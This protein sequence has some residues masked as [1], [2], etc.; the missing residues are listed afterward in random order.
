[1]ANIF[2]YTTAVVRGLAASLPAEAQRMDPNVGEV[3]FERA[4]MQKQ[5]YVDILRN[6]V[7]LKVIE[8]PADDKQPDCVFVEDVVVA[9]GNTALIT[10]PGHVAR[11]EEP[12]PMEECLRG[13]GM[14][15]V[16]M[17]E[18]DPNATV[19]GGDVLF[20]GEEIFVGVGNRSNMAGYRVLRDTFSS[21]PVH[22]VKVEGGLH[23]KSGFSLAKPG[24][25]L[26]AVET[27]LMKK[28]LQAVATK[29]YRYL[30]VEGHMIGS[31]CLY[32]D[33]EKLGP[34]VVHPSFEAFPGAKNAYTAIEDVKLI[35]CDNSELTKVDGALTCCSV[36][37]CI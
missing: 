22:H 7:G 23:L 1:M 17:K 25:L 21:Y 14:D 30:N 8:L 31:N 36:L 32:I 15:V 2:R 26:T 12:K 33:S 11:Q 16:S 34:V 19:D 6:D 37:L 28:S 27:Q 9:I 3:S 18:H 20:T 35:D 5:N 4:K 24:V 29:T 13:L 10:N